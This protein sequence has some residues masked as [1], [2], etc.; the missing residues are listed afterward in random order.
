MI[1]AIFVFTFGLT[2]QSRQSQS[3]NQSTDG[4]ATTNLD[5]KQWNE[6]VAPLLGFVVFDF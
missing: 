2:D 5:I 3:S 6:S 1:V 4:D